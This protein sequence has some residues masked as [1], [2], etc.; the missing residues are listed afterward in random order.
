MPF[1]GLDRRL[2]LLEK[3]KRN[4]R[5]LITRLGGKIT[6]LPHIWNMWDPYS[7]CS[8]SALPTDIPFGKPINGVKLPC[9]I[10]RNRRG[11]ATLLPTQP[12][13]AICRCALPAISAARSAALPLNGRWPTKVLAPGMDRPALSIGA[14][15]Q[16]LHSFAVERTHAGSTRA[17]RRER[18]SRRAVFYASFTPIAEAVSR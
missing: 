16:G 1:K 3:E 9:R 17:V 11:V 13:R 18:R 4:K 15:D 6:G 7:L 5:K 10:E 2:S 14:H 12:A 8:L